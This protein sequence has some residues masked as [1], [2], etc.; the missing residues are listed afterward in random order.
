MDKH[1]KVFFSRA[2]D[3]IPESEIVLNDKKVINTLEQLN[4]S[5]I[6]QYA[7]VDPRRARI[8]G[9]CEI[10]EK[11]L[12]LLL[13]ADILI[14]DLSIVGYNYVGAIFEI[15]RAHSLGKRVY[16]W[17]GES[18]NEN[19][20]WMKYYASAICISFCEVVDILRFFYTGEGRCERDKNAILY[21]SSVAR[22]YEENV[23]RSLATKN[24]ESLYH[25]E[26]GQFMQWADELSLAG[27]SLDIGSGFGRWAKLFKNCLQ[28]HC[29][30]FSSEMLVELDSVSESSKFLSVHGNIND[31]EWFNGYLEK[32]GP[33]DGVLLGFILNSLDFEQE[34]SLICAIKE[35][36]NKNA[37]IVIFENQSSVFSNINYFSKVE[38]QDRFSPGIGGVIRM[39]KRN[40]LSSDIKEIM[41]EF[42]VIDQILCTDNYFV[43]G[44]GRVL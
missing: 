38:T 30:D 39:C 37:K 21:Y 6:N 1:V 40:F 7:V 34:K 22:C 11:D 12:S 28:V 44:V 10:V 41:G 3:G 17:V 33:F 26:Y 35:N 24:I 42:C 14:A 8:A 29:I 13:E 32:S 18:N 25:C 31:N 16:V 15:E 36:T 43:M 19:R 9:I 5:I 27:N 4:F 20:I 23:E 2:M